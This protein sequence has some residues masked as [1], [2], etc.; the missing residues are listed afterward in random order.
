MT[1]PDVVRRRLADAAH[2]NRRVA[3]FAGDVVDILGP[4]LPERPDL[5]VHHVEEFMRVLL[6][7]GARHRLGFVALTNSGVAVGWRHGWRRRQI[8]R[9]LVAPDD[10]LEV[11]WDERG[12]HV[13]TDDGAMVLEW[14]PGSTER[15]EVE[16]AFWHTA[17]LG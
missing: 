6:P 5:R 8:G 11:E 4:L 15:D 10:A 13:E 1:S 14:M 16:K 9:L 17:P 7:G 2:A 3:P 12:L